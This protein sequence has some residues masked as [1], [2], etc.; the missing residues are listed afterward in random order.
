MKRLYSEG[1]KYYEDNPPNPT[2]VYEN[3]LELLKKT[4]Y[5]SVLDIGCGLGDFTQMLRD[6]GYEVTG[7][8]SSEQMIRA[9]RKRHP[10]CRFVH[11]NAVDYKPAQELGIMAFTV[12]PHLSPK[13][14]GALFK[15]M[16]Q[17]DYT[18]AL[19]FDYPKY[20]KQLLDGVTSMPGIDFVFHHTGRIEYHVGEYEEELWLVTPSLVEA[21][22]GA[23]GLDSRTLKEGRIRYYQECT[24][25]N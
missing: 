18:K 6:E 7:I 17:G 21:L 23:C 24:L 8:D 25:G 13:E 16:G 3:W 12:L 2:R 15:R 9:A 4:D 22:T 11:A 5:A 1:V 10:E 20:V 14:L 19:W